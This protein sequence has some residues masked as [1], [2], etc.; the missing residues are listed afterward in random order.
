MN[1]VCFL[2][3]NEY[4]LL[5]GGDSK[6]VAITVLVMTISCEFL[7]VVG[8][9]LNKPIMVEALSVVLLVSSVLWLMLTVKTEIWAINVM[10]SDGIRIDSLGGNMTKL[11]EDL[12]EANEFL[13][14][15]SIFSTYASAQ[16]VIE[17][18]FQPSGTD[19]IIHVLGD[20]KREKYLE[21]FRN[22][23]FEYAVTINKKYND[24]EY[25]IERANWF[26]YRELY[27]NYHPVF[28][29]SYEVYWARN[30]D[31]IKNCIMGDYEV[32]VERENDAVAK[33][34]I[35]TEESINGVADVYLD[36]SVDKNSNNWKSFFMFQRM[37]RVQPVNL[38]EEIKAEC[39]H[40][41]LRSKSDEYIP[42]NIVDGHGEVVLSANPEDN[43]IL[44]VNRV[45]CGRI[46]TGFDIINEFLL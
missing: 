45:E 31:G 20:E 41:F 3:V 44:T 22:S 24:W 18:K 19:Y 38:K 25:W 11:G 26:F 32:K 28:E 7:R 46:F 5:S 37:L 12:L 33:L 1:L 10:K 17:N 13:D 39:D 27:E 30:N 34:I 9:Y 42:V 23:D 36:Y 2:S 15:N 35:D 40:N 4:K 6:E 43:S 21:K 16:E 29:N 8:S 14:G